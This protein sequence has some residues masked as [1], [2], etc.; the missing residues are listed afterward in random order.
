M[1]RYRFHVTDGYCLF[2]PRGLDLP[3]DE[4]A[5]RYGQQLADGFAPVVSA[6]RVDVSTYIEVADE[7]GNVISRLEVHGVDRT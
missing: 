1:P 3:D 7:R 6:L 4:A 2:D 5:R